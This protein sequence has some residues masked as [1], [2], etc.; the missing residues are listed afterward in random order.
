MTYTMK[1]LNF[2]ATEIF[3][4]QVGVFHSSK[5]H[6]IETK[7]RLD[8]DIQGQKLTSYWKTWLKTLQADFFSRV[9]KETIYNFFN[10]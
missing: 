4:F 8:P 1:I 10:M 3:V 9:T 7:F 2:M 6:E 5:F